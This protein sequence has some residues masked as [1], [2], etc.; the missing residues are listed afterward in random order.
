MKR[1]E[2]V[3][4]GTRG[5]S[6]VAWDLDEEEAVREAERIFNENRA[7]G[8]AAFRMATTANAEP[9]QLH[10]FDPQAE[11]ILQFPPMAGG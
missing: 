1:H 7:R 11:Q 5:D 2:L 8:F 6:R 10:Q 4:L 9:E 3:I